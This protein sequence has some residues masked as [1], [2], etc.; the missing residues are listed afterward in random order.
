MR[1]RTVLFL[2]LCMIMLAGCGKKEDAISTYLNSY[3]EDSVMKASNIETDEGYQKYKEISQDDVINSEGYYSSD[4]V[5]YS[6]LEDSDAV[7]VTFATNSYI[8]VAYFDDPAKSSLLDLG[9]AYLHGNDC[10]YAELV[11][12]NNPN[13]DAYKFSGFEVWEFDEN[14]KKKRELETESSDDGLIYQIPME[15]KGREI[16]IIPLGEYVPRNIELKDYYKDNNGVERSLAGT[17]DING[18]KT[19]NNSTSLSP[20]A[21]Y[22]VTYMY[23]P[24]AYVFVSSD[25]ICLHNNEIDGIVSFEEFS[26][27][28]EINSFSVELHKKSGDQEFDPDKYKVEHAKIEYKY[29]GVTITEPTFIPNGSKISYEVKDVDSGYWVPGGN[30]RGEIEISSVSEVISNLVCKEEKV[31]VTLPQPEKGGTITYS[32]DGNTLTGGSVEALIGAEISMTF[33]SKNGWTCEFKDGTVY[34][35]T[36]KEV[37]RINVDGKDVNNI[38][39][40]QQYKP[41]VTLTIDKSV[42]LYTDFTID[43]VDGKKTGLNLEDAKKNKDVF[44]EEVGTKNDLTIYAANGALLDGEA[45]KFEI[46][47]ETVDGTKET[48]IQYL[49][50]IPESLK[51]SLYISNSSTVYKSVKVTAS[52]VNVVPYKGTSVENGFVSIKTTD[53][54]NNRYLKDGDVIEDSRKIEVSVSAKYGYYVKDSGK[55]EIYSDMMKYSKYVDDISSILSK[56]PVKKYCKLT[57][58]TTDQYGT[59][60]FKIDGKVVEP[61]QYN[62]KE[63]QKLE[64]SYEITDGKHVIAREAANWADGIWDKAKSKTKESATISITSALDERKVTRDMYIKVANK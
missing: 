60:T 1:K 56:H 33:K 4:D 43:T 16:A 9:G 50:K 44:S 42:G 36:N 54:S 40:E 12:I 37:Q 8:T 58:D 63:E 23:D 39:T 27:D 34:K 45:L 22:T 2:G 55:T 15:F 6:V 25:P 3:I 10:I 59:V 32:M 14:G 46:Q 26:A 64:V 53:I 48:D 35:V 57:L 5:D 41:L 31:K 11:E 52:K 29:Q 28:Q 38:F 62:L 13:T 49:Q 21:P 17:W 20:V 51:I 30:K 19:T 7:H 47:K 24:N 18:D 61:G